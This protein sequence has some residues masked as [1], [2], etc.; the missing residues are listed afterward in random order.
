MSIA[1]VSARP[2]GRVYTCLIGEIIKADD[3]PKAAAIK[4]AER[5]AATTPT[6]Q[7]AYSD[8]SLAEWLNVSQG[9]V[10]KHR[11]NVCACARNRA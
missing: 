9:T 1:D 5:F 8:R 11:N 4:V 10:S 7:R 6:G 2:S 3:K